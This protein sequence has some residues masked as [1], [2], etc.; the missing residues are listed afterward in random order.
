MAWT[1]LQTCKENGIAPPSVRIFDA[2]DGCSGATGRNG[3][4]ILE[5]ALHYPYM[6]Q[7]I[8][9]EAAVKV[10]KFRL[11]HLQEIEL[12]LASRPELMKQSQ[13]RRVEFASVY[14]NEA[15]F[16]EALE[17]L[18]EFRKDMPEE[19]QGYSHHTGESLRNVSSEF[20]PSKI[21]SN[22]NQD[23]QL[24]EHAFG[25]ITG[26]AGAVWPYRLVSLLSEQLKRD[27]PASFEIE[28][29]TPISEI[30]AA[31]ASNDA[32]GSHKYTIATSRGSTQARQ[33]IHCTNGH[34]GHLVPG[35]RGRIFPIRG[36]MSAQGP[37][38][39]FKDQ[40]LQ[41]SWV[42]NY[43]NGFDY[44]T[45]LPPASDGT[46]SNAEMMFGGGLAST[47]GH[48]VEEIGVSID[49]SINLYADIHL[50]G[51][52]T[53]VF[54]RKQWGP[55]DGVKSMWTGTMGFSCDAF[56]WVG[57]LPASLT[58]RR[59]DDESSATEWTAAGYSGEGMVHAWLSG[60]AVG[61][62]VLVKEGILPEAAIS[63]L[64]EWLPD[65]LRITEERVERAILPQKLSQL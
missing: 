13:F 29:N 42:F 10:T 62:M 5:T 7:F 23:F 56:P 61:I 26:P 51:A 59:F 47:V 28:T 3:G 6:K 2:R 33:I 31:N 55:S 40:G 11:A 16:Q 15:S 54:D 17:C 64:H 38:T 35:L 36:Q 53:A 4:H 41:R 50:S 60:K 32:A 8:G 52:L 9:Q 58:G 22:I 20:S 34:V 63:K 14:F 57:E 46:D 49:N 39:L 19:S 65:Q 30:S 37:G 1:I 27:F 25:V 24:S 45:Q 48:G 18:A 12:I 44:L 21:P 43:N